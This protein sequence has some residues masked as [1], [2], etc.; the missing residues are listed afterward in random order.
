[1][2]ENMRLSVVAD[3]QM[4]IALQGRRLALSE[5]ASFCSA[6]ARWWYVFVRMHMFETVGLFFM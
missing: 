1:M 3:C 5:L 2:V 6:M 4:M